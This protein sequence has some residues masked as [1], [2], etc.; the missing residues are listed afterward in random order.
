MITII[1]YYYYKSYIVVIKILLTGKKRQQKNPI[2]KPPKRPS[3]HG[4]V[5]NYLSKMAPSFRDI[6]KFLT[7]DKFEYIDYM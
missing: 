1:H 7:I 4:Q 2:K 6:I 3:Q 5:Q